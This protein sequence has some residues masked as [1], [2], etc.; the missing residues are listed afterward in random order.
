MEFFI[1]NSTF[2]S[3]LTESKRLRRKAQ[4]GSPRC[5]PLCR[6]QPSHVQLQSS[7]LPLVGSLPLIHPPAAFLS[8]LHPLSASLPPSK[9]CLL[10][11]PCPLV[12]PMSP[13]HPLI[14][15]LRSRLSPYHTTFAIWPPLPRVSPHRRK[16]SRHLPAP[17]RTRPRRNPKLWPLAPLTLRVSIGAAAAV[18]AARPTRRPALSP[19][20]RRRWSIACLL[21]VGGAFGACAAL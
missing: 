18:A 13:Q 4:R 10:R 12:V 3:T 21:R 11:Q 15:P 20:R 16:R 6:H 1:T 7:M 5:P 19:R 9:N 14:P 17:R 8:Q 2:I